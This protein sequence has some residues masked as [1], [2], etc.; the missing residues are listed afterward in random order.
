MQL[1]ST[2]R[3]IALLAILMTS[4]LLSGCEQQAPAQ[5]AGPNAP[6]EV[7]VVTIKTEPVVLTTVLPGRS[8]AFRIAEIRPQVSG[9]IQKRLFTEGANVEAG[10]VLY[11][12]DSAPFQAELDKAE[13]NLAVARK[14]AER[15]RAAIEVSKANIRQQEATLNFSQKNRQRFEE[16]TSDGAVS[17]TERDQAVTQ[18]E[19]AAAALKSAQAQLRRDQEAVAEAD[20]AIQQ[21]EAM[22]EAAKINLAYT[23]IK[24]P[25]SGRIGK[26]SVTEGAIV[27]AY[28]AVALSSIQQLDPIYVDVPQASSDLLRLRERLE[29]GNLNHEGIDQ[30]KVKI[31][32]ENGQTYELEGDLQFRDVSVD[33]STGSVVLRIVVPNPED[34][35]L[36]GMFVRASITEGVNPEAIMV[37]Q[38][39]LTRDPKGNPYVF[40]VDGENKV[41]QRMLTVDRSLDDRWLVTGGL[42]P[43]DRVIMEGLQKIRPG[44]EVKTV[45][46]EPAAPQSAANPESK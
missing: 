27:T 36:P 19:V 18:D 7:S 43:G 34:I 17:L 1:T 29:N 3:A 45:P 33:P 40:I 16:L 26:S 41:R 38:Q 12:I 31:L 13:A 46:F 11:Q 42:K 14:T 10:Q 21:A 8:S 25:I 22:V 35:L 32:L 9:L 2:P 4:V 24:A 15:T 37:P 28:Q 20:A 39:A 44:A 23:Q 5:S 30:N 6:V